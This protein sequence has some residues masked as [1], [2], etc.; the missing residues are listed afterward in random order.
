MTAILNAWN[1][2]LTENITVTN[3]GTAPINGW[4]LRFTLPGGQTIVSGWNATYSP[5]SGQV[6]A[7]NVSYNGAIPA[8]GSLDIGFQANHTGNTAKP[9]DFTLNGATC[10]TA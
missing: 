8:G 2:G 1:T 3:T 10:T 9:T 7:T 4:S 5:A 6:T